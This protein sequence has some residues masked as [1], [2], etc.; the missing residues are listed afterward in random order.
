M[1]RVIRL[2]ISCLVLI[3]VFMVTA[4]ASIPSPEVYTSVNQQSDLCNKNVEYS[5]GK[6]QSYAR[7]GTFFDSV[8]VAITDKGNGDIG[9]TAHTYLRKP[10]KELYISLYLDRYNKEKDIWQQVDYRDYEFTLEEYPEGI[11][12]PSVSVVFENQKKGYYYRVRGAFSAG[13]DEWYEGLG[14]TTEGIWI[15]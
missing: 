12:N 2:V 6:A 10:V 11:D 14:P 5:I 3:N 9:V 1:K 13:D 4:F 15:E 7:R 8:D